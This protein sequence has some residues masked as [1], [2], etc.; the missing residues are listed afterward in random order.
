VGRLGFVL[1]FPGDPRRIAGAFLLFG[2]GVS[3]DAFAGLLDPPDAGV[4]PLADVGLI[5]GLC[6][7]VRL[8]LGLGRFG[9]SCP[10]LLFRAGSGKGSVPPKLFDDL[11][12]LGIWCPGGRGWLGRPGLACVGRCLALSFECPLGCL[13]IGLELPPPAG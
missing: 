10:R 11:V 13:G 7:N 1:G 12:R 3:G 6:V 2:F 5:S 8:S 9:R 4:D